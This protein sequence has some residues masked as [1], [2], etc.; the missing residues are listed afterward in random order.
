M[1]SDIIPK[2][3]R[4]QNESENFAL[5]S[6]DKIVR[7][8]EDEAAIIVLNSILA[9]L[10][11]G[12]TL[13][14]DF[15]QVVDLDKDTTSNHDYSVANGD[16]FTINKILCSCSGLGSFTLQIGDGAASE[17]FTTKSIRYSND[18]NGN[19][20]IDIDDNIVVVGTVNTTTVRIIRENRDNQDLDMNTTII[21]KIT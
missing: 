5:N 13:V 2:K 21:G 9:Q 3:D 18:E 10:G 4:V 15:D 14:N 17:T 1:A 19:P 6:N 8:V 12:G 11:G 16:T 20:D 7:R